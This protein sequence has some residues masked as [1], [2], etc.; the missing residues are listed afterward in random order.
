VHLYVKSPESKKTVEIQVRTRQHHNWAT[1]VEIS[2]LLFDLRMKEGIT[3][4][5]L[6]RMHHLLS[7]NEALADRSKREIFSLLRRF[8][9]FERLS[10]A[11]AS[12]SLQV[13]TK[14]VKVEPDPKDC[15]FLI[16]A[17]K[18]SVPKV[19][20]FSTFERAEAEYFRRFAVGSSANRVLAYLPKA[21]FERLCL[22][23]SN[24]MLTYHSFLDDCFNILESLILRDVV[25]RRFI[26]FRRDYAYYLHLTRTHMENIQR[27]VAGL[28]SATT[29]GKGRRL[30]EWMR[31]IERELE[32]RSKKSADLVRSLGRSLPRDW[33]SRRILVASVRRLLTQYGFPIED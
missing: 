26:R 28:R 11:F 2:D 15:Y 17:E 32:D 20:S 13:R 23:Y 27:E 7:N 8:D 3:R 21:T 25:G 4:S 19:D 9:Y 5:P 18:D 22:A 16:E 14:W 1:L 12:N 6:V 24:Y 30:K 10:G 29:S 31:D 33:L